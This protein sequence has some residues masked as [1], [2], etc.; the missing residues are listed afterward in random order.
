MWNKDD[1]HVWKETHIGHKLRDKGQHSGFEYM[2][3]R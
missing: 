3:A 1:A 2:L